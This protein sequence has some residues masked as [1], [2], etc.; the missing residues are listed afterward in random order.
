VNN[1]S[2]AYDRVLAAALFFLLVTYSIRNDFKAL[3]VCGMC[4]SMWGKRD[5]PGRDRIV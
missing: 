2:I 1:A 4:I 5:V 3:P